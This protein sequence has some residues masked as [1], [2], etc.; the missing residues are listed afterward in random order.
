LK[1][2]YFLSPLSPKKRIPLFYVLHVPPKEDYSD[3][4]EI[5][6]NMYMYREESGHFR[7]AF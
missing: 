7:R 3:T 2:V 5:E 4:C 1:N 6:T